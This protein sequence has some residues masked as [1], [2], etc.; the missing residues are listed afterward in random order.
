MQSCRVHHRKK[1]IEKEHLHAEMIRETEREFLKLQKAKQE[2]EKLEQLL[3]YDE[4]RKHDQELEL[5]RKKDEMP[6]TNV[7]LKIVQEGNRFFQ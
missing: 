2:Q 5:K 1:A 7:G 6:I 3:A 4:K